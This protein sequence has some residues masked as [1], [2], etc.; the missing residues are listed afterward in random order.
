MDLWAIFDYVHP[1]LVVPS[2]T[3][4]GQ[5]DC[6][7]IEQAT[8]SQHSLDLLHAVP[9]GGLGVERGQA[10]VPH[11]SNVRSKLDTAPSTNTS[12]ANL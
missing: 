3:V 9:E 1:H 10:V 7:L 11:C 6:G 12:K 8:L 4:C 5:E 2:S